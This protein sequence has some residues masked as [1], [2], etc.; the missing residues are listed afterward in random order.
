MYVKINL[1]KFNV[2]DFTD[3]KLPQIYL[4]LIL[5]TLVITFYQALIL[6]FITTKL[7]AII[8]FIEF[9]MIFFFVFFILF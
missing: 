8:L 9:I 3:K 4:S 5:I 1:E 6:I 2:K 7:N